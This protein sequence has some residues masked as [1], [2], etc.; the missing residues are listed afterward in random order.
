MGRC[1]VRAA[2]LSDVRLAGQLAGKSSNTVVAT[3]LGT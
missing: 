3:E 2:G 1:F